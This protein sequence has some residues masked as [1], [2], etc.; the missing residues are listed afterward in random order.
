MERLTRYYSDNGE[1]K[2][3]RFNFDDNAPNI[4]YLSKKRLESLDHVL[5]TRQKEVDQAIRIKEDINNEVINK[6]KKILSKRF[7]LNREEYIMLIDKYNL[8]EGNINRKQIHDMIFELNMLDRFS[9]EAKE[10][11]DIQSK[12][13]VNEYSQNSDYQSRLELDKRNEIISVLNEND[14]NTYRD[15]S[16]NLEEEFTKLLKQREY[17]DINPP[18]NS[19]MEDF[20]PLV[21]H[22]LL[23]KQV[24]NDDRVSSYFVNKTDNIQNTHNTIP[25]REPEIVNNI[26]PDENMVLVKSE[27]QTPKIQN[28]ITIPEHEYEEINIML[29]ML[30][31]DSDDT[32]QTRIGVGKQKKIKNVV[33]VELLDCFVNAEFFENNFTKYP[34]ILMRIIELQ[35]NVFLNGTDIGGFCYLHW[36]SKGDFYTYQNDGIFGKH[37]CKN[38]Q[39]V[40]D[41]LTM[42]LYSPDGI[43]IDNITVSDNDIFN[44]TLK[45]TKIKK[46]KQ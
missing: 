5:F 1:Y 41:Y 38:S 11:E 35:D 20:E 17:S 40:L 39:I 36:N 27:I 42:E 16:S 15:E 29:N 31:K 34:Y 9:K 18:V 12:F 8:K 2:D 23:K 3:N 44:V 30:N 22:S 43:F 10:S 28:E 19:K 26:N 13:S 7:T 14:K 32:F 37:E 46:E 25:N 45:I 21:D 6:L 4:K 24:I 33:K